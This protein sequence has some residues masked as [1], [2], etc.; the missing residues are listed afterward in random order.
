LKDNFV[1][2]RFLTA[3]VNGRAQSDINWKF[4][5]PKKEILK[6]EGGMSK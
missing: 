2:L 6:F 1:F 5:S 3:K 4:S